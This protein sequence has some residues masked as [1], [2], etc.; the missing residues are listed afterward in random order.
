MYIILQH[1]VGND[2]GDGQILDRYIME[3]MAADNVDAI[4]NLC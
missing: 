3:F 1:F 2:A 4:E